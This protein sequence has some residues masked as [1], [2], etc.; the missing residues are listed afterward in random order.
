MPAVVTAGPSGIVAGPVIGHRGA[1]GLAPENTLAGLV[2]AR[3]LGCGWVEVDA[4]LT[5]DGVIVL[6]HDDTLERTTDGTGAVAETDFATIRGLDAGGWFSPQTV[7]ERVPALVEALELAADLGLGVNVEIKPCPGREDE[8]AR[9]V[10][11]ALSEL[12][13]V[14]VLLSSFDVGAVAMAAQRCPERPR[15]L[16]VEAEDFEGAAERAVAM[17]CEGLHVPHTIMD[18]DRIATIRALGLSVR[19]FTVNDAARAAELRGWGAE[20]VFSDF[21]DRVRG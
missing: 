3:R 17:A 13:A 9:T 16:L 21:P 1:A 12:H 11:D 15:A 6:M 10:I 5:R 4:K 20:A 8:T 2:V 18:A 7:G 19:C 14:G